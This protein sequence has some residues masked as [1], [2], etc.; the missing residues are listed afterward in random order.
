MTAPAGGTAISGPDLE[1]VLLDD[2]ARP[3]LVLTD[4]PPP[5]AEQK[6]GE[7]TGDT[8]GPSAGGGR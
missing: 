1:L 6:P 5:A 8:A 7:P 4:P 2:D 3:H